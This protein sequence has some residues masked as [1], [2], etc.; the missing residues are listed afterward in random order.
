MCCL[1]NAR[2]ESKCTTVIDGDIHIL[3]AKERFRLQGFSDEYI[4]RAYFI[5]RP[6]ELAKQAGNS[7]TVN[8]VEEIAKR[9]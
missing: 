4:N 2:A 6:K 9:L 3:T 7:V 5:N 1:P 8:V